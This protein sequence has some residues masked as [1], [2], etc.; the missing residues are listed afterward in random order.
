MQLHLKVLLE[1][2]QSQSDCYYLGVLGK[3]APNPMVD[4]LDLVY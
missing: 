4:I 2:N 3:A 1:P